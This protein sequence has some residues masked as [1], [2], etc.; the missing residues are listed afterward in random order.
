M[1]GFVSQSSHLACCHKFSNIGV[2]LTE[3]WSKCVV[4]VIQLEVCVVIILL[5]WSSAYIANKSRA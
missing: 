5:V 3:I 2:R 4:A 1:P